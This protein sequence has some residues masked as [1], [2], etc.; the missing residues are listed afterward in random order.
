VNRTVGK[1]LRRIINWA[2]DAIDADIPSAKELKWAE[3][4]FEEK[5]DLER[6][7]LSVQEE[8]SL[9]KVARMRYRSLSTMPNH[10]D[11]W[12]IIA[13]DVGESEWHME[14]ATPTSLS[15]G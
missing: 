12:L 15:R 13:G 2:Y 5:L 11:D 4:V 1:L 14:F 3:V 10:R 6:K 8:A 7:P 9:R